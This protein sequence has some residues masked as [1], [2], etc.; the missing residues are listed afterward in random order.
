MK[1]RKASLISDSVDIA[2]DINERHVS[3]VLGDAPL[4][5]NISCSTDYAQAKD[6]DILFIAVPVD[7]VVD[8]CFMIKEN[9][10]TAPVVLCSKGVDVENARVMSCRVE[11]IIENDLAIFSGPSFAHEIVRGLPFGV[12]IASKE[13]QLAV[14]IAKRLSYPP[15]VIKPISDYIGL[16]IAGAFKNIL[17]IGCGI[18]RGLGLGN[19]AVAQFIVDGV[20]EMMVLSSAMDGKNETFLELGGIGD[21]ILTCTSEKSRNVMFGEHLVNGGTLNNWNG[22]L[23]EGAIAAK[24]IPLFEKKYNVNLKIFNEIYKSIYEK[25]LRK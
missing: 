13:S 18:K 1:S 21:I 7:S 2:N 9:E 5:K 3:K 4:N 17:A 8:V 11:E 12:N 16:Q 15:F 22:N 6:C 23:A 10:I 24:S 19:S 25:Q 20:R 14:D